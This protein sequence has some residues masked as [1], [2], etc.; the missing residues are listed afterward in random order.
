MKG[1][2]FTPEA[3]AD[4][5]EIW[6]YIAEDDLEAANRVEDAIHAASA[7]LAENPL[8]GNS[9]NDLTPLPVRF[10]LVQPYRRYWIVYDPDS[11]P[12]QVIRLLHVARDVAPLLR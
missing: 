3:A 9:R 1:Y 2:Q 11:I 4:L 12:L 10:W 5:F 7:L 8:S 6:C